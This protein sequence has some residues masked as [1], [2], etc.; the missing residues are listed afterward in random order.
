MMFANAAQS[1][2]QGIGDV[3]GSIHKGAELAQTINNIQTQRAQI[4]QKK[5]EI[6]MQKIEKIG[7]WYEKAA[8]MPDGAA[9]RAFIKNYIPQGINALGMGDRIHPVVQEMLA[10]EPIM[11]AY[12]KTKIANGEIKYADVLEAMQDPEKMA[13]LMQRTELEKFGGIEA[14]KTAISENGKGLAEADKLHTTEVGKT[15][16]AEITQTGQ[17]TRQWNQI[18]SQGQIEYQKK[19]GELA[20]NYN[21]AGGSAAASLRIKKAQGALAKLESG[22][23]EMG[24]LF[25]MIPYMSDEKMLAKFDPKAK[26]VLD[27]IRGSVDLKEAL[28]DPNPT[29]TQIATAM[30]RVIDPN[31]SNEQNIEKVKAFLEQVKLSVD[32]SEREF[33]A[34]GYLKRS[35]NPKRVSGRDK[36]EADAK[37][38]SATPKKKFKEFSAMQQDVIINKISKQTGK[39]PAV[40]RK[41]LEAQ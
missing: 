29:A 39:D 25:K 34:G 38:A 16:R 14:L 27:D 19:I 7:S 11:P 10:S 36:S 37:K 18:N 24:T 30:S 9:R 13:G 3:A 41:E 5:Q 22:E 6:D 35:A 4:E 33:E 26:A 21:A 23:V 2:Q 31:L 8:D 15:A 28:R 40:V 32:S 17:N 1:A 20:A 12:L